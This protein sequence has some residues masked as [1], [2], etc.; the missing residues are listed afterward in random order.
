MGRLLGD[1]GVYFY[2]HDLL[3]L[4]AWQNKGVGQE[5]LAALFARMQTLVP[6]GAMVALLAAPGMAG[7]Y[8]PYGFAPRAGDAPAVA[9]IWTGNAPVR[10]KG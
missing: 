4:P 5:I 1:G 9:I 8:E 7:Y 2:I 3:V 10:E 6:V